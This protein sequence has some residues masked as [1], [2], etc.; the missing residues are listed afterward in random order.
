MNL[1]PSKIE[2]DIT[3]SE[4]DLP[5]KDVE[6]KSRFS[7]ITR[8]AKCPAFDIRVRERALFSKPVLAREREAR[9]KLSCARNINE[10][11]KVIGII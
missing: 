6:Q 11:T 9:L 8:K 10:L 7:M 2:P 1:E 3:N 4:K 5:V